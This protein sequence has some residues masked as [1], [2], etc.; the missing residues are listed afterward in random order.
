MVIDPLEQ[1]AH[2]PAHGIAQGDGDDAGGQMAH[3]QQI[4]LPEQHKGKEHDHHGGPGISD[5]PEHPGQDL[6]HA[7]K[8]IE[9]AHAAD[10]KHTFFHHPR[11][12][13][14][15]PHD[16]GG[17]EEFWDH[18]AGGSR[19]CHGHVVDPFCLPSPGILAGEGGDGQGDALHGHDHEHIHPD[20]NAPPGSI[21]RPEGIHIG[22]DE[23]IGKG[24]QSHLD[25]RRQP[26]VYDPFQHGP[27]QAHFPPGEGI[28]FPAAEKDHQHQ[29]CRNELAQDGGIGHS[30]HSPAEP[31][32]EIQ[33]QGHVQ[34]GGQ[35]Q[36][37]QWPFGIPHR[38]Q[39]GGP[40]VVDHQAGD[41]GEVDPQVGDGMRC[42]RRR[43]LH[44]LHQERGDGP[45]QGHEYQGKEEGPHQR[46]VDRPA[47]FRSQFRPEIL[48]DHHAGPGAQPHEE[49]HQ[50]IDAGHD[51]SHP[52]QGGGPYEIPHP[53]RIHCIVQ[54]LEQIPEKEGQGK[55]EQMAEDAA[56]GH[57]LRGSLAQGITPF[58]SAGCR[59]QSS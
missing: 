22:L 15:Q 59:F 17:Q 24:C 3:H 40:H 55:P 5:T 44:A 35:G 49:A 31:D 25:P 33:V 37:I 23:N 21:I 16:M 10:E 27:V 52:A 34:A 58:I 46:G 28:D 51:G 41:A 13:V 12:L 48:G 18:Q 29:H 50:G 57:I 20:V 6:V 38:P 54:L 30:R 47:Q 42:H 32:D 7:G 53:H 4:Q 9:Q 11:F 19:K 1:V 36:E 14:E 56:L 43:R 26:H 2:H 45:A 8:D 39:D